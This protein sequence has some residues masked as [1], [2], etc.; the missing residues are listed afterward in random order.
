LIYTEDLIT[1]WNSFTGFKI[2]SF[3]LVWQKQ[4]LQ[5]KCLEP[6]TCFSYSLSQYIVSVGSQLYYFDLVDN[7]NVHTEIQGRML[8]YPRS[9]QHFTIEVSQVLGLEG[10]FTFY[11]WVFNLGFV[12]AK[13]AKPASKK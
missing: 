2:F 1:V 10:E 6:V 3:S 11:S 9:G 5:I 12:R 13:C 4:P 8:K 7:V